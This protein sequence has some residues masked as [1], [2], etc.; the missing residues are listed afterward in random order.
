[1]RADDLTTDPPI[2]LSL[3]ETRS[4]GVGK[5]THS[6]NPSGDGFGITGTEE[7]R[8]G[9]YHLLPVEGEN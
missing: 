7:A 4:G 2:E 5:E 8:T 6:T 9:E 1:M 3:F